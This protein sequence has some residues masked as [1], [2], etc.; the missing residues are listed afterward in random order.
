MIQSAVHRRRG[1]SIASCGQATNGR[2]ES[3]SVIVPT[4]VL[5]LADKPEIKSDKAPEWSIMPRPGLISLFN[6]NGAI[7]L[8]L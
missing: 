5:G 2:V 8:Q 7:S 3:S 1:M 4:H 6:P